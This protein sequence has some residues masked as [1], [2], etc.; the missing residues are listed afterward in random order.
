MQY[1]Y[2]IKTNFAVFMTQIADWQNYPD[3]SNIIQVNNLR[4]IINMNHISDEII[5]RLSL[6]RVDERLRVDIDSIKN[7]YRVHIH[8]IKVDTG[9]AETPE[10]IYQTISADIKPLRAPPCLEDFH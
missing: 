1:P 9:F 5:R 10:S 6:K 7:R 8:S 4:D 2:S 3:C